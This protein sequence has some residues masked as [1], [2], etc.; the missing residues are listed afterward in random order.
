MNQG[1]KL[2]LLLS[3]VVF[4]MTACESIQKEE[5]QITYAS[6]S[7]NFTKDN[8]E[9]QF[10]LD[11]QH[12]FTSLNEGRWEEVILTTYPKIHGKKTHREI[13]QGY[14]KS[15][16]FGVKR[17][18]D[19]KKIE[20]ITP[21]VEDQDNQYARIYYGAAVEVELSGEAID[22]RD[23]IKTDL[24]LSYDTPDVVYDEVQHKFLIDAYSSMIAISEKG[25]NIWK[26]IDVDKQK[27]SQY[28]RIIP[29]AVLAQLD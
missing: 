5:P 19:L 6:L 22:Q 12:Y 16:V 29:E 2:L 14:I 18:V 10:N 7:P 28:H 26:Y 8:A 1:S 13:V 21:L 15:M 23:L 27:E 25:S 20:R 4:M 9:K 24:E 17:K 3:M 11:L